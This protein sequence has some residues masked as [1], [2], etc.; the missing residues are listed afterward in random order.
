[1]TSDRARGSQENATT[2]AESDMKCRD[3][4]VTLGQCLDEPPQGQEQGMEDTV[5]K[6]EGTA[7]VEPDS[8][9]R[10]PVLRGGVGSPA[11]RNRNPKEACK[12]TAVWSQ[13]S[14]QKEIAW[15]AQGAEKLRAVPR[16][17]SDLVSVALSGTAPFSSLSHVVSNEV[18]LLFCQE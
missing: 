12:E 10:K 2:G 3:R 6:G 13:R 9:S 11:K 14:L 4:Q 17:D 16:D 18:P 7:W 8:R 1:M 5:V 15:A